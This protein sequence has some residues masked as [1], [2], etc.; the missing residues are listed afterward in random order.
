MAGV[1]EK[2][3]E[4]P[5]SVEWKICAHKIETNCATYNRDGV[6]KGWRSKDGKELCTLAM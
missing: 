5:S 2:H 1:S 4:I 6:V 3:I